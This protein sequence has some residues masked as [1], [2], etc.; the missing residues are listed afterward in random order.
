M[1]LGAPYPAVLAPRTRPQPPSRARPRLFPGG[2]PDDQP[3]VAGIE[4]QEPLVG[5]GHQPVVRP[6]GTS[7]GGRFWGCRGFRR[8]RVLRC[9]TPPLSGPLFAPHVT[10]P[11]V[12]PTL[13][14]KD[15][16]RPARA[17]RRGASGRR[18]GSAVHVVGYVITPFSSSASTRPVRWGQHFGSA[19]FVPH[20][21]APPAS[22]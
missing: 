17:T 16:R 5:A 22:S 8:R 2:R 12:H 15:D 4:R 9:S 14:A 10:Y 19:L 3:H 11:S 6:Q 21:R 1:V 7:S 13:P 18:P 20:L